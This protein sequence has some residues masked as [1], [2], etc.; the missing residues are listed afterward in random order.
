MTLC[1]PLIL[2]YLR[3]GHSALAIFR[4]EKL[5]NGETDVKDVLKHAPRHAETGHSLTH[6]AAPRPRRP[7]GRRTATAP[8]P[9]MCF[10]TEEE[11][12]QECEHAEFLVAERQQNQD[13]TVCEFG[14]IIQVFATTF[15]LIAPPK[16][17]EPG[18][19]HELAFIETGFVFFKCTELYHPM[20]REL[21]SLCTL[22]DINANE[23]SSIPLPYITLCFYRCT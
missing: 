21:C 3:L 6:S 4:A 15:P 13:C 8:A 23:F 12:D 10:L 1:L 19:S 20:V 14:L 9:Q 16:P 5:T 2:L 7:Q 22:R 11:K 18:A 17:N